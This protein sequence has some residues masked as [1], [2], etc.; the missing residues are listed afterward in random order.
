MYIHNTC[1]C[2]YGTWEALDGC[3]ILPVDVG[4][5][6]LLAESFFQK[7]CVCLN[8]FLY[9]AKPSKGRIYIRSI[10]AS[11]KTP[12]VAR[13][14]IGCASPDDIDTNPGLSKTMTR[15]ASY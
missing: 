9:F 6:S 7:M 13:H 2:L 15:E 14:T 10:S 11:G 3:K 8:M 12:S 5:I 1:V 4:I